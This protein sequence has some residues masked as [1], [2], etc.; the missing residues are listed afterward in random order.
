MRRKFFK[1]KYEPAAKKL[2]QLTVKNNEDAINALGENLGEMIH[3]ILFM[4]A[5]NMIVLGG[6]IS[7]SYPLFQTTLQKQINQFRFES[8]GRGS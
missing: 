7:K 8:V 4:L 6:S 2:F 3:Q 5:L 1:E